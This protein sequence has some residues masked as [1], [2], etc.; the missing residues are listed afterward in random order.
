MKRWLLPVMLSVSACSPTLPLVSDADRAWAKGAYP[1]TQDNL[2]DS[3]VLYANKCGGCHML[4]LP[5]NL[6]QNAWPAVLTKMAPKARLT[7]DEHARLLRYTMTISRA[8]P[9]QTP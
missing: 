7:D 9:P 4:V 1:E 5:Y 6:P 3:R 2:D 8:G